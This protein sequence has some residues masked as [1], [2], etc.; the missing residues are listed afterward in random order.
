MSWTCVP[1]SVHNGYGVRCFA[2]AGPCLWNSLRLQLR[3]PDIS[4]N[5]F[6]TV[7]KMFLFYVLEIAA[8]LRLIIKSTVYKYAYL[9]D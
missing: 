2:T 9:Q 3:E 5:R 8:L 6:K 4:F 1:R 7:L